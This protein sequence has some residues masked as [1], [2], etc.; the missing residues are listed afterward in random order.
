MA[1]LKFHIGNFKVIPHQNMVWRALNFYRM[2]YVDF[3][4]FL[5]YH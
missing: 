1:I 4:A 3:M 5:L 2:G